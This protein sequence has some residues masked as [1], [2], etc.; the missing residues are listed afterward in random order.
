MPAP[1]DTATEDISA[2][3]HRPSSLA[4]PADHRGATLSPYLF[5][6][7]I[8]TAKT[9]TQD[10]TLLHRIVAGLVENGKVLEKRNIGMREEAAELKGR[11]RGLKR[12]M[13]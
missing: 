10:L 5:N 7:H 8:S 13:C 4:E 6:T 2:I 1:P 12:W 11:I 9:H 3:L